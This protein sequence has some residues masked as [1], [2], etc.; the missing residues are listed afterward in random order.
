M[1]DWEAAFHFDHLFGN[2][3]L[4]FKDGLKGSAGVRL[5]ASAGQGS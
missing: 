5:I 2:D 1:A 3:R 4:P